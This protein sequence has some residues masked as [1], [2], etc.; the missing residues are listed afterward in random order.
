MSNVKVS[1]LNSNRMTKNYRYEVNG[2]IIIDTVD[3]DTN[4]GNFGRIIGTT[5]LVTGAGG[6]ITKPKPIDPDSEL[7]KAIAEDKTGDRNNTY[8][9]VMTNVKNNAAKQGK[10]SLYNEALSQS[11][12]SAVANGNAQIDAPVVSN[13]GVDKSV[14]EEKNEDIEPKEKKRSNASLDYYKY[15][16]DMHLDQ[17]YMYIEKF[18]YKPPQ[19][20]YLSENV[21]TGKRYRGPL[22]REG[23]MGWLPGA[24][25][26]LGILDPDVWRAMTGKH[27]IINEYETIE[28]KKPM[29]VLNEGLGKG[30]NLGADKKLMGSVKLP[31]P[32]G[33]SVSQGVN[34]GEGRV[35]ALEAGAFLGVQNQMSQLIAGQK[36]LAGVFGAG[37]QGMMDGLAQLKQV[38][39]GGSNQI[40]SSLLA[41]NTLAQLGINVDSS[42]MIAR[43]TGTAINPNLELLFSGPKLRTFQFVFNFAPNEADEAQEVRGIM[44]MF[45]EGMLPHNASTGDKLFL[46]APDVFRLSY[47][48]KTKRI[49][50]LNIFKICALTACE[51][52]FTPDNQYQSYEDV[53][54]VSMPVRST[55]KLTF[56]ELSPIFADDYTYKP[57]DGKPNPSVDDLDTLVTGENEITDHDIGF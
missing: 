55:M 15:P 52:N 13:Q 23:M 44:R 31:I 9:K 14:N 48:N 45:R 12:M 18:E 49:K 51:I 26:A 29:S 28:G 1:I 19:A 27:E 5:E 34:W 33:L 43:S 17:D 56:T 22:H 11:G 54:A 7:A 37:V 6:F 50:S 57:G 8:Q 20:A 25:G 24:N 3:L 21:L 38:G 46:G 4:N 16:K 2:H 35:N 39:T 32:N 53:A 36:N 42:Q 47:K 41:K 30:S 40:L 10:L